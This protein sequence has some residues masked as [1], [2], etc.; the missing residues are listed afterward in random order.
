MNMKQISSAANLSSGEPKSRSFFK[1]KTYFKNQ[2]KKLS[3][4]YNS[5]DFKS[6]TIRLSTFLL[7]FLYTTN[8]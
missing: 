2:L 4:L 8:M 5:S 1:T 7:C 3:F 6:W